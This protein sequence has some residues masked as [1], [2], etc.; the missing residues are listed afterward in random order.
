MG[1]FKDF[2]FADY[3]GKKIPEE[4]PV[5]DYRAIHIQIKT[6]YKWGSGWNY[7]QARNFE[8]T[9]YPKLRQAGYDIKENNDIVGSCDHLVSADR[10]EDNYGRVWGG[11]KLD[12]Y[13]HPMEFSGYATLEDVEKIMDILKSCPECIYEVELLKC[14]KVYD[15]NQGDYENI[16]L[17][18]S[19]EIVDAIATEKA[20]SGRFFSV[21]D[22]GFD[23]AREARIPRFGDSV[24]GGY[25]SS[26]VDVHTVN[27]IS[28]MAEK[29]GL[30][31]RNQPQKAQT[32]NKADV[33]IPKNDVKNKDN[34]GKD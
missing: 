16:I 30:L 2:K 3:N 20:K 21:S 19:N 13:M 28:K 18:S 29:T 34:I 9:L 26:D 32:F 6:D 4:L 11:N 7:E 33:N 24:G 14:D 5:S 27:M 10:K 8:K 15:L 22:V 25:G 23:F 1:T 17:N 12:L 31:D